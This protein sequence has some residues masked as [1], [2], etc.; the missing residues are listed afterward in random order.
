MKELNNCPCCAF[1]E[2]YTEGETQPE[3]IWE[4][5]KPIVVPVDK[6]KP[7]SVKCQNCGL[8]LTLSRLSEEEA[9]NFWNNLPYVGVLDG[10]SN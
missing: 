1:K 5:L 4:E 9:I 2:E 6:Y 10:Y 3:F 7:V 8:T